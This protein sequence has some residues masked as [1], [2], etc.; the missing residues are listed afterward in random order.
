MGRFLNLC[1]GITLK[2]AIESIKQKTGIKD[3]R[4]AI[5]KDFNLNSEI[6]T[7]AICAGSGTSILSKIHADLYVTGEM[8]HHEVLNAQQNNISVILCN[9]SNSERGYLD[10]FKFMLEQS[11]GSKVNIIVSKL[12]AD[13]LVTY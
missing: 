2:K 5:G 8:S 1:P 6:K 9:H 11:L 7:A 3:V 10:D 13:P 4:V 12:D